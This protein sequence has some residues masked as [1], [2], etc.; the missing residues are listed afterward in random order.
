MDV[1][2]EGEQEEEEEEGGC[3]CPPLHHARP[4]PRS[5]CGRWAGPERDERRER[6]R[7]ERKGK[8][9][10]GI[11][12][13]LREAGHFFTFYCCFFLFLALFIVFVT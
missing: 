5:L 10:K 2:D 9:K 13:M 1:E 4:H 7:E 8:V 3:S 6:G 12:E 11:G